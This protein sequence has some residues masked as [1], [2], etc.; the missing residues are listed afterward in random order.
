MGEKRTFFCQYFG[1]IS[2][3]VSIQWLRP[4]SDSFVIVEE[5]I[6]SE[7]IPIISMRLSFFAFIPCGSPFLWAGML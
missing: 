7:S 4:K 6:G 1:D 5:K 2:K 3:D